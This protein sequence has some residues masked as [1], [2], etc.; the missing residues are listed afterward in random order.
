MSTTITWLLLLAVFSGLSINLF[1][2]LGLG[3][4]GITLG[5][6][7]GKERL[8]A[9]VLLLFLSVILLW[10]FFIFIRSV[11]FMGSFEYILLFPASYLAFSVLEY[12]T[13]RFIL[14]CD[15]LHGELYPLST[16]HSGAALTGAALFIV[17]N[18]AS[19]FPEALSLS[20]GFSCGTA[21]VY[22]VVNEIR[23]R[24]GIES[25]PRWL[26]GA[27]LTLIAMGLL[28]LIFSSGALMI[29]RILGSK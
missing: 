22:V 6:N 7:I 1:L 24:A 25:V 2:Q 28:S 3:I 11:F 13:N 8:L 16:T 21:L 23:R 10:L 18:I 9:G 19:D 12:F 5:V 15:A 26:R 4:R 14:K 29:F 20:L 17:L 27:P